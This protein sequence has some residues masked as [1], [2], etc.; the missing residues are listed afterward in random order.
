MRGN[1]KYFEALNKAIEDENAQLA[2]Y[3]DMK[4]RFATLTD[5]NE[6]IMP[7][8]RTK[9]QKI[10]EALPR[11]YKYI[12]EE[13]ILKNKDLKERTKS[14]LIDYQVCTKDNTS[15]EKIGLLLRKL[16]I[17]PIKTKKGSEQYYEYRKTAKELR[18]LYESNHWMN[19]FDLEEP[20]NVEPEHIKINVEE[21]TEIEKL[22]AQIEAL[23]LENSELFEQLELETN[24]AQDLEKY[25]TELEDNNDDDSESETEIDDITDDIF[26]EITQPIDETSVFDVIDEMIY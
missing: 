2:F 22:K 4:K 19:E 24:Y 18:E 21:V 15:K 11:L 3:A 14:F 5:W 25:I 1:A 20:D 12:K 16:D 26:R 10:C 17:S 8:T 6:D 7:M 23:K 13:Y 9:Q